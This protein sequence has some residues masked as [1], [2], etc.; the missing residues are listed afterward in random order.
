MNGFLPTTEQGLKALVTRAD[1][2]P[3]P[4][5]WR[6]LMTQVPLDPWQNEYGYTQPGVHNPDSFDLFS[7][8]QDRKENTPDDAGNWDANK[9]P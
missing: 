2:E 1:S 9:K 6:Q 3:R 8:G 7:K 4:T 5:Q